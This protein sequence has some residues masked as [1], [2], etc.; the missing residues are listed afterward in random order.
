M[1]EEASEV[2]KMPKFEGNS[3]DR[4][5]QERQ[6]L[7]HH[8]FLSVREDA[9][10]EPPPTITPSMAVP[11]LEQQHPPHSEPR[12]KWQDAVGIVGILLAGGGMSDMPLWFRVGC[13][14]LC[15]VCMPVSFF[16]H[17]DW[18]RRGQWISSIAVIVLMAF[19]SMEAIHGAEVEQRNHFRI[20]EVK[21]SPSIVGSKQA[22][23]LH[24]LNTAP[25]NIEVA[26]NGRVAMVE[27]GEI[28]DSAGAESALGPAPLAVTASTETELENKVWDAFMA[29]DGFDPE[30]HPEAYMTLA[31]DRDIYTSLFGPVL[32]KRESEALYMN[33]GKVAVF[34]VAQF[35]WKEFGSTHLHHY[36]V[37][38]WATGTFG[39]PVTFNCRKHNGPV[40]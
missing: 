12:F 7:S 35:V 6:W 28:K 20:T 15:A 39:K 8:G 32:M 25:E 3:K 21:F 36:E 29:N 14:G 26:L 18:P 22:V 30:K 40:D 2:P 1:A 27:D 31:P 11:L 33:T 37:C 16:S 34:V 38:S 9:S 19:M 10:P 23:D 17:R 24:F 4:R 5:R 13:F